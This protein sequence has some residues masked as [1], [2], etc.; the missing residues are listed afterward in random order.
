MNKNPREKYS[1][2]MEMNDE[3]DI[4]KIIQYELD[5]LTFD[6]TIEDFIDDDDEHVINEIEDE[7][8]V[9]ETRRNLEHEMHERLA[10]FENEIKVNLNRFEIDY[11]EI[12]ELLQKPSGENENDIQRNVARECGI[13]REELN[14]ILQSINTEEPALDSAIDSD[15]SEYEDQKIEIPKQRISVMETNE[16][17]EPTPREQE[18]PNKKT[19]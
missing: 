4:D 8:I 6:N 16:S 10:A 18:D 9:N 2:K 11:S 14:R 13:D 17:A 1:T 5:T 12:D 3:L 15:S 19:T 7:Q